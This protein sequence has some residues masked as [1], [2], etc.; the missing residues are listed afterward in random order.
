MKDRRR[1]LAVGLTRRRDQ[2]HEHRPKAHRRAA[3]QRLVGSELHDQ[4]VGGPEIGLVLRVVDHGR[5]C[6]IQTQ[7]AQRLYARG[8]ARLIHES[9][10]RQR[11]IAI[12]ADTHRIGV[13]EKW[14]FPVREDEGDRRGAGVADQDRRTVR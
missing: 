1:K 4:G 3:R 9:T 8:V 7:S 14:S 11:I 13:A 2:H 6:A 5:R 12:L 10:E